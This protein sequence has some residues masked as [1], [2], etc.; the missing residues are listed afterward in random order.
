M[1]PDPS[2]GGEPGTVAAA[3]DVATRALDR[4]ASLGEDVEDEWQYVQGVGAAWT[5]RLT[6]IAAARGSQRASAEAAAAVTRLADEAGLIDDPHRAI[7]WLSTL[8]QAV[9]VALGERP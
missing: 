3:I 6:D 7:D 2:P 9:C 1:E 8:P 4:L 5:E